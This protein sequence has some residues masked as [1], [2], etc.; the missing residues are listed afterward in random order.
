[1]SDPMPPELRESLIAL[2][3]A[4]GPAR[5]LDRL[6]AFQGIDLAGLPFRLLDRLLATGAEGDPAALARLAPL[7]PGGSRASLPRFAM[8]WRTVIPPRWNACGLI[9]RPIG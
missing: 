6:Q 9:L 8:V 3:M 4:E 1:M 2:A 5:L 7:L